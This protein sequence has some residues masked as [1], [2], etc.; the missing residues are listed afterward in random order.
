MRFFRQMIRPWRRSMVARLVSGFL[1]LMLVAVVLLGAVAF[2]QAKHALEKSVVDRLEVSATL[3]KHALIEWLGEQRAEFGLLADLQ[4]L[5][6]LSRE[7]L[8]PDEPDPRNAAAFH[9][10]DDLLTALV[11]KKNGWQELFLLS[12][13][14][15]VLISTAKEYE[16]EYRVLERFFVEGKKG[17]YI[18]K[19]YP[20]P[21][22]FKPTITLSTP[23][24]PGVFAIHLDLEGP[25]EVIV[26]RS[27]LG[28]ESASYLVD[29]FRIPVHF[30]GFGG[31]RF[32]NS[33]FSYGIDQALAMHEGDA[34]YEDFK[35]TPVIGVYR[36][37]EA[38]EV[39]LLVE[40]PQ[41][42]AYAP[43]R[44]I[45]W[46]F[47]VIG[48]V[49][50][51][52][53]GGATFL[54]AR[55]V[56]A[57]VLQLTDAAVRVGRGDLKA[58]VPVVTR[59]EVGILARSFNRMTETLEAEV[60]ERVSA[61]EQ[62]EAVITELEERN[63]ELERFTYTVSHDL[64]S[65][66][67]TIRGFLGMLVKDIE[68]GAH[69]R[70]ADDVEHIRSATETMRRLL[71][72]LLELSRVGRQVNPPEDIKLDE[73]VEQ[74]LASSAGL[75]SQREVEIRTAP[76]LGYV[77][78][79][80][81]RLMEVFQNLIDNA[82]NFMGDQ[83]RPYIEIGACPDDGCSTDGRAMLLCHV[84]DNGIGIEPRFHDRV[85]GLFER[86]DPSIEGTGI[87][88][89]LVKRIVELHGGEIRVESAGLG[90]GTTFYFTLPVGGEA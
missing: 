47:V 23:L 1:V 52:L 82:V 90:K 34:L 44:R 56:A 54:L 66:L 36:W 72:E 16:G 80:R 71:E 86:L 25:H 67:V 46:L 59:D 30:E 49:V 84:R 26:E 51:A 68:A 20:S 31:E 38:M 89:A 60:A 8:R 65:P 3:K 27:G 45:L 40:I 32:R 61:Q 42:V 22:T 62:R 88:L 39:A 35:G 5:R 83:P 37:I 58:R 55:E 77:C 70:I 11:E 81:L 57:P 24:D 64:K 28:E 13:K 12:E 85:F 4:T 78:G 10:L 41:K 74:A 63:A 15:E 75:I 7:L 19:L 2:F 6:S 73:L 14:G 76:G 53:L 21:I 17:P 33:L 50:A 18:E 69:D 29:R 9:Q 79:D 48:A 87:G 43:A